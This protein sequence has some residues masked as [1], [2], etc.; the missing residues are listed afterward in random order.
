MSVTL[1][2]VTDANL[3]D[4]VELRTT[5][6]QEQFVSTV[7]QSLAEAR[8]HPEGNP[9]YRA[10]YDDE[11]PVGFVMLSWDVV[12]QPPDLN[13]PWF[14]WKLLIDSR[15]QGKGYGRE[16]LRQL[17]GLL[18]EQGATELLTSHVPG[19]GGP[20]GFYERLGFVPRGDVDS[21]GEIILRLDLH[22]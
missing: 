16:V 15:Y 2:P 1:R 22:S 5:P 6:A 11:V 13:G 17:V 7:A 12:P 18:R 14:L 19:E 8:A 9:W 20:A 4:V 10:V 3:V 21:Q